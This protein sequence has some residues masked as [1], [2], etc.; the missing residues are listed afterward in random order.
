MKILLHGLNYAPEELGI[1]KYSG[2][3]IE[4]LAAD[5]HECVVVTAPPYYPQWRVKPGY[6]AFAYRRERQ[7]IERSDATGSTI[8][9]VRC[10]LWVPKHVTGFKRIAHLA[11]FGL[12]SLPALFWKAVTFRPDVIITVEPSAFCM[13]TTW[14]AA[15][16]CGAKAWLHVQDFEVDAAFDLGILKSRILRKLVMATESF[17]MRRFDRASS[18]SPTMLS[19]LIAKG[20]ADDRV[21]SLPNWVDCN[22]MRPLLPHDLQ[23]M[24]SLPTTAPSRATSSASRDITLRS[25]LRKSFGIP[26]DKFVALYA[27]NIGAKQ[28]LEFLVDAARKVAQQGNAKVHFVICGDGA[29]LGT[30]EAMA[31]GVD[32]LQLL[33]V[34]PAQRFN[35]LMNCADVHL[36]TQ[37]PEA[38]DLVMPSKLT[39]MLATG[40]AVI[41]SAAPGT[42]IANVVAGHGIVV[43]PGDGTA[44][45]IAV[46]ELSRDPERCTKLGAAA[47][48]YAVEH[49][50]R[51]TILSQLELDLAE[52]VGVP[53]GQQTPS[54][55][56]VPNTIPDGPQL[57][58]HFAHFSKSPPR[59]TPVAPRS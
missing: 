30:I 37:R 15:R 10:P 28:G 51:Q 3:M 32:Y 22:A 57:A 59:D 36:L 45:A 18:I 55:A 25:T 4:H 27:G 16:L 40:R 24:S 58:P 43:S 38:A 34:Q 52:L 47:R 56:A 11:S 5:G 44:I 8:D 26:P 21:R 2:E 53:E 6:R 31:A 35:E 9:V 17:L 50:S 14:L 13:P 7:E 12:S 33:P 1:G 46:V 41:A 29:A 39:G 42:Q 20:V 19:R 49:L 23:D 54:P 48:R